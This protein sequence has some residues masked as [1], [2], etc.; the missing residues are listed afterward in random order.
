MKRLG[1]YFRYLINSI[2][3]SSNKQIEV[4]NI[5]I[6]NTE[7]PNG[8]NRLLSDISQ[9][10]RV[11]YEVFYCERS[12]THLL[13][14]KKF[15]VVFTDSLGL[16]EFSRLKITYKSIVFFIEN[17]SSLSSLRK[18]PFKR[19]ILLLNCSGY[20]KLNGTGLD[21]VHVNLN[22]DLEFIQ[23]NSLGK[24]LSYRFR[25]AIDVLEGRRNMGSTLIDSHKLLQVGRLSFSK[26]RVKVKGRL[27]V[28]I[29]NYCSFG[30]Q[31]SFITENHDLR[32]ATTQGYFY[33]YYFN[34]K[35]PSVNDYEVPKERSKGP[36]VVEHDVWIGDNVIILSGVR[37]GTGASIA[38]GSVVTKNVEPY[39]VVAGIPAETIRSR[40]D[41]ETI[42]SMKTLSWW[43]W[44]NNEILKNKEFFFKKFE[45]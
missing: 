30:E 22:S 43:N 35:H 28:V 6:F 33:D 34:S 39:R 17:R 42:E 21:S 11:D 10:L 32:F 19:N 9:Y 12:N 16:R 23:G 18:V 2:F 24:I 25:D 7:N 44:N 15:D 5:L 40:F 45:T 20:E 38:A 29:G 36:I 26:T 4:R 31:V 13:G 14:G 37:I 41:A 27:P 1:N 8:F 3:Y